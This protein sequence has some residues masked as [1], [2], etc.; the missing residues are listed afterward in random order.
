VFR[1]IRF[2][3]RM[4]RK[5]PS[6]TLICTLTLALGIGATAA[7]FSLIQGVLLTPPPYQNPA[8]L[9]LISPARKDAQKNSP[10]SWPAQQWIDWRSGVKSFQAVAGYNWTFNFL[11]KDD[12]SESMEGM[13]VSG[14]YFKALG[15]KAFMGRTFTEAET[16]YPPAPVVIIGYDLW[17]RVFNGDPNIVGKPLRMSR[18]KTPPTIVGVM[19]RGT[20]FLPSPSVAEEPNYNV[21]A[22]VDFWIPEA[23]DPK[24]MKE[25]SWD[26]MARLSDGATP[27]Q[28]QQELLSTVAREG[29]EDRDFEGFVPKMTTLPDEMN[30]EGRR[31]LLPLLGAAGLVLLIACG[32][33][34]AL[35]LV[36]GL[37]RQ[38]EYAVRSAL[39]IGRLG[40]FR[41]VTTESLLIA[42]VGGALG[43]A[44][45][46]GLVRVFTL[47]GGHAVPRLDAVKTGWPVLAWGMGSAILAALMAGVFPAVRA[48][49][50][51]PVSII[52]GG[53]PNS[54][55]GRGE[56]RLM[57][58]VTVI[59]TALTL[60]LLVGAGLLIRTMNNISMV[61]SGF[62]T[63]HVLTMSVTAVQGDWLAFHRQALD[64]VSAMGGVE[65]AAFAWGV[66][67]TGN[68]WQASF[69][70]EGVP[71]AT[72]ASD[73]QRFPLR[74]VT[75]GYFA[76]LN[77]PVIEG[78]DF[79]ASDDKKAPMVAIVN[80]AFVDRYFPKGAAIGKKLWF[81]SMDN[82]PNEIV[83][84]IGNSRTGDLTQPAEP[85]IYASLWQFGAFSKHLVVRT[86]A[87]P[88]TLV[89]AIQ[90]ELRAVD[91]TVAVE[92]AKTLEQIRSD[93]LASRSFAMDLLIGFSLVGSA[94][95]L[96]GIYGVLSLSV[97]SRR[98]EL[99]IRTAVGAQP[100]DLRSLVLGE[101][102][103][104]IAAGVGLGIATALALA[105]VLRS[106][107]FGLQPTDPVTL[108]SVGILFTAV[109]LLACWVPTR[110]AAKASPLDALRYE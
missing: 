71:P 28:A 87:D 41:Q 89:A 86:K 93:S 65:A 35:L 72:K 2:G 16:A 77:L 66:P 31:I 68:D 3:L 37:Q 97:A 110:R 12:G 39:G 99:A 9:V 84:V 98:R 76:L 100:G 103:R 70:I 54:S 33:V 81:G 56:R 53:G 62:T 19:P 23:L 88:R 101:G 85:E 107:L 52:K 74:S 82:K 55:A 108:V 18:R 94:L 91:P 75:P 22:P 26:V 11:V 34:A 20:R 96:V 36:R 61:R 5:Q 78:R 49:R 46:F 6:F 80:Q 105:G 30:R 50:L 40:L 83:G 44:L 79:R 57:R 1:D 27:Q 42:L 95:T 73:R 102:L 24:Q 25:P 90:R 43:V 15:L 14:D 29:R 109:A 106:F 17:Q 38:Q 48:S 67:L 7:V 63:S 13:A 51:D 4:L 10:R 92:N 104:L 8:Q 47:I 64:R 58:G 60:A 45:A 59:Q 21:N 69:D 32:N